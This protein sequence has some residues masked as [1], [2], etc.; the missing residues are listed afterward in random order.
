[1]RVWPA[2]RR[3]G[4]KAMPEPAQSTSKLRRHLEA[5]RPWLDPMVWQLVDDLEAERDR[6]REATEKAYRLLSNMAPPYLRRAAD[7]R[8]A[9]DAMETLRRAIRGESDQK[10]ASE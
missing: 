7:R 1:M 9:D 6:Y 3:G 2:S 10:Q 8:W 4:G 5:G